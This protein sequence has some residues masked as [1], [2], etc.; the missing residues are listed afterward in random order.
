MKNKLIVF[1]GIDGVGKTKLSK[2]LTKE[3]LKNRIECV[4]YEDYEKDIGFNLIKSFV[5]EECEIDASLFFYLASSIHKS[6]IIK[7]LLR[8]KWVICDRYVYSALAYHKIRGASMSLICDP[9]KLPVVPPDFFFLVKVD[10]KIRLERVK[11]RKDSTVYDLKTKKKN[12]LVGEMEAELERFKPIIAYNTDHNVRKIVKEIF[13]LITRN[14]K[15]KHG[16]FLGKNKA[17][18]SWDEHRR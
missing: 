4:R 11:N 13:E 10:E 1:E 17:V 3:L 6:K 2:L 14:S 9:K 5:K 12:N 16:N 18:L 8:K 15:T 7:Q